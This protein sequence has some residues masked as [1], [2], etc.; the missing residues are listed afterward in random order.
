[1][2]DKILNEI[3]SEVII[4]N[5]N[6]DDINII[7]FSKLKE[8][9]SDVVAWLTVNNT[10]I[11]YPVLKYTDNKYY[12]NHNFEKKYN[13]SGWV[14]TDYRNNVDGNDKNLVIYAHNVKDNSMFGSLKNVLNPEWYNNVENR[15]ISLQTEKGIFRY[16]VFSVYQVPKED[17]Y[18]NTVFNNEDFS[19]FIKKV[20]DRSINN[21]NVSVNDL[22]NVITLSTCGSSNKYRT[23]LHAKRV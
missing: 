20:R 7:D 13:M 19:D 10:N 5:D 11:D 8:K 23:V 2:N 16:E 4:E 6:S 9:N 17:Y 15:F 18:I 21:F 3:K 12:L 22:D 14:F 1:M